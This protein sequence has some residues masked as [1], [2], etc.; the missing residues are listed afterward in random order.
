[1]DYALTV[2]CYD[3]GPPTDDGIVHCGRCDA[4]IL[5]RKGFAGAGAP[6]PTLYSA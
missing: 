5:R 3:P 4:C 1:M 6:D 2:S